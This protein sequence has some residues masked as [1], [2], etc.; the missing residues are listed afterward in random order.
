MPDNLKQKNNFLNHYNKILYFVVIFFV[1]LA[2]T[3]TLIYSLLTNFYPCI[4]SSLVSFLFVMITPITNKL[5]SNVLAH[6]T[7]INL[8]R[9][10]IIAISMIL[11]AFKYI[12]LFLGV[13]IGCAINLCY[14]SK[15]FDILTLVLMASI[16][17]ISVLFTLLIVRKK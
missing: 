4:W 12:F 2:L 11:F 13:V 14:D 5:I 6:I 8:P 10:Q 7:K 15:I 17:P 3:I 16:Y 1:L 9:I